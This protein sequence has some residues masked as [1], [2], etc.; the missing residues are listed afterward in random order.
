[1]PFGRNREAGTTGNSPWWP[2]WSQESYKSVG[3][4]KKTNEVFPDT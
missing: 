3:E 4:A 1:M 2:K